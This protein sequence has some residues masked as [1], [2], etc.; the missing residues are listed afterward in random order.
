MVQ[1]PE[2]ASNQTKFHRNRQ[3]GARGGGGG[4]KSF[5][6]GLG[7]CLHVPLGTIVSNKCEFVL[8]RIN[9]ICIF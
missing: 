2:D 1:C 5:N 3:V 9:E 7:N 6:W 4:G 8:P